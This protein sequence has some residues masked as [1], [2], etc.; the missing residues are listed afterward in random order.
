[1]I[2]NVDILGNPRD[3]AKEAKAELDE[4]F[5]V[6]TGQVVARTDTAVRVKVDRVWK[7]NLPAEV[8]LRTR[9]RN[10]DGT[11]QFTSCDPIIGDLGS[12][13]LVYAYGR[14]LENLSAGGACSPSLRL[15]S[16]AERMAL[17]DKIT[18]SATAR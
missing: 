6:F 9:E 15:E 10:P 8:L 18:E 16:A 13:H 11:V 12:S 5:A 2:P 17:L 4:A 3:Y 14:S 1:M 7:G